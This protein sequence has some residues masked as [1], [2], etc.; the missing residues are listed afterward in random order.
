[1]KSLLLYFTLLLFHN[2]AT[3]TPLNK[4]SCDG[5]VVDLG[6]ARHNVTWQSLT[7]EG[8]LVNVYKNIRF[9]EPAKRFRKPT[10]P[11]NTD[12]PGV[13]RTGN[14]TQDTQCVS[15][16]PQ[17]AEVL[18]PGLNGT[19]FGSEDCLF[20]DVYVPA[21]LS[22]RLS[23]SHG[24]SVP[25]LHWLYGSAYTFG[26]KEFMFTPLGLF[27][28]VLSQEKPFILVVSNYRMGVYG[29]ASSPIEEETDANIG[30][31]DGLAA[32]RWSEKYIHHFG[33][34]PNRI[35]AGGQSTGAAIVELLSASPYDTDLPFQ[36]AFMS[37]PALSLKGNITERRQEVFD[38]F[39]DAT[40]CSSLACLQS[41]SEDVLREANRYL[42]NDVVSLSGGG[43]FGPGIGF[44]PIVDNDL[45]PDLPI[46]IS[47]L[48][49]SLGRLQGIIASNMANEV[50]G[51]LGKDY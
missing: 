19:V 11:P 21:D 43:N 5:G 44:G 14:Y 1:M 40:N 51:S 25:V 37:S 42:I 46:A 38:S 4:C 20:L 9:A 41:T 6:Y 7:P 50:S 32:L 45:V 12:E 22:C 15:V 34:D 30:L 26:S 49:K 10:F 28:Q 3:A 31:Y 27:D 17:G 23:P 33:G 47:T 35:T 48:P 24:E 13:V 18:F 8:R 2:T 29:W 39:L 16:I 36:Q